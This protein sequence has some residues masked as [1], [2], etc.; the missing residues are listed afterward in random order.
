MRFTNCSYFNRKGVSH[1]E[2]GPFA[3]RW[4]NSIDGAVTLA[5]ILS[6]ITGTLGEQNETST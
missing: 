3:G 1:E 4:I 5:G 2:L 6:V